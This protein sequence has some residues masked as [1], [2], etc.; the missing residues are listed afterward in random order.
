MGLGASPLFEGYDNTMLSS[1]S[2]VSNVDHG[3][4]GTVG[5]E[6]DIFRTDRNCGIT[7]AKY[8]GTPAD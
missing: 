3:N 6:S 1:V 8:D 5:R 2:N 4:A 7:N